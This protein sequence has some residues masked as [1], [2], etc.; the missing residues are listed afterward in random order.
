MQQA[1]LN[2]S[3][4]PRRRSCAAVSVSA[5][6]GRGWQQAIS[7]MFLPLPRT[8]FLHGHVGQRVRVKRRQAIASL[9][10]TSLALQHVM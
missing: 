5:G 1:A 6:F 8:V 3:P 2:R 10:A 9:M 4:G 7:A